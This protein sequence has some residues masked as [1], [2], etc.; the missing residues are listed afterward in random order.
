LIA[1]LDKDLKPDAQD[2]FTIAKRWAVEALERNKDTFFELEYSSLKADL[3]NGWERNP[4]LKGLRSGVTK[5]TAVFEL[6]LDGRKPAGWDGITLY[7]VQVDAYFP[8]Y[9][10]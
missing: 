4:H 6:L 3:E 5:A 2:G 7:K 8:W 10:Y 1:I 9:Y